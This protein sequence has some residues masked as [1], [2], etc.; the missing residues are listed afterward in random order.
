MFQTDLTLKVEEFVLKLYK[1]K[2][3]I[4]HCYHSLTHAK[5]V[6]EVIGQMVDKIETSEDEKEILIIAGW[7]HDVGYFEKDKGHEEVSAEYAE[8]F[9]TRE[10]YAREK[11]EKVKQCILATKVPTN[12]KNILEEII[13]DADLHHLGKKDIEEK[14]ELFRLELETKDICHPTDI[15]WIENNIKFLKEHSYYTEYAKQAFG[16]QK[17]L[18]QQLFERKLRKLRKKE[19]KEKI[20]ETKFE[21]QKKKLESRIEEEKRS[22]RGIETMFRNIMRTHVEFSG[23][24]DNKANIMITV[25]TLLLTIIIS[26]LIRKLDTNPHLLLPTALITIVSLTTLIYAILVTRPKV[27]SG[28]FSKEDIINKNANLM[29]FGNFHKMD[30]QEFTWGMKSMMNDKDYLYDSMIKDFYYLGQVL[31]EKYKQL[32]RC[33]TIF[34]YGMIISVLAYAIAV[35]TSPEATNLTPLI[36]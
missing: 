17:N 33:Y 27:T 18:N 9:L 25:N 6:V 14:S 28:I 8:K 13:C 12:P 31:G 23:M 1:D 16:I 35:I 34:M 10:G 7:F 26:V 24:A 11:I 36:D 2:S 32:R 30:L 22:G 15:E 3:T 4:F 19:E 21:F 5:E 29:F 20:S